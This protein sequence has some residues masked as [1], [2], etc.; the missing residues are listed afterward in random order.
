MFQRESDLWWGTRRWWI[1]ALIGS[2]GINALLG[3]FL[4]VMPP[5]L[6]AAGEEIDLL[7]GGA[8][9]FFGLGFMLLAVDVTILT[10]DSVLGERQSG[11]AEWVLSKPVSRSAFILSK[12]AAHT[13]P[14]LLLLVAL[15]SAVAYGLFM[16]KGVPVPDAY[17]SAVGLMGLH[18]FFYLVLTIAGGVLI[19]NRNTLLAVTLGSALGGVLLANLVTPYVMWTPWPLAAIASGLVAGAEQAL[20]RMLYLPVVFTAFWSLV[21]IVA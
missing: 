9:M 7:T 4:F 12:L 21:G 1:Q 10:L 5:I 11:T 6:E 19:D 15:P 20:P 18:T 2:V 17:L 3:F 14:I 16:L 8:Q 13:I